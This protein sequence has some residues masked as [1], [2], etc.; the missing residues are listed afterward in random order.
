MSPDLSIQVAS[1]GFNLNI[2]PVTDEINSTTTTTTY[3]H[4]DAV[5]TETLL[6]KTIHQTVH[7]SSPTSA[8]SPSPPPPMGG[9]RKRS[10]EDSELR[11]RFDGELGSLVAWVED[12]E[13]RIMSEDEP[14]PETPD[15]DL[16]K[17][18]YEVSSIRV[19]DS[20]LL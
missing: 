13:Q 20:S 8:S 16:C 7:V 9:A 11:R 14:T 1:S 6:T 18:I 10:N 5:V 3:S 4:N 15:L 17:T 2:V 12:T 19:I